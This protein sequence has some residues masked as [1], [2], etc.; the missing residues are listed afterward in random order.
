MFLLT[1]LFCLVTE[2]L[3]KIALTG[4]ALPIALVQEIVEFFSAL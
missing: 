4:V 2:T 3:G 1:L